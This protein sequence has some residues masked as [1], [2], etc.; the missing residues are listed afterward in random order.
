[1][2]RSSESFLMSQNIKTFQLNDDG[3]F[4]NHPRWPS[5]VYPAA[6]ELPS[7]D[8]AE[9][10]E[11]TFHENGWRGAWRNGIYAYQHY[12]SNIHEVLGI[13]SGSAQVQFGGPQGVQLLLRAGDV[14]VLP[15][16]TAHRNLG[17]SPDFRV[18]GA[19]PSD[20]D[21]DLCR[22]RLEEREQAARNI[23]RVPKPAADP[24]FGNHGGLRKL[25]LD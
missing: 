7:D 13:F 22:G 1:M 23:A 18:V 5:L 14:A 8:P 15:A 20:T 19:Y 6:I 21:Y 25:W 17:S 4:P 9:K 2:L 11:R 16:G 24:V 12:H 10:L 3:L